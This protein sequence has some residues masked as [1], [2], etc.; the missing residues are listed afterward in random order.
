M[1]C[2]VSGTFAATGHRPN[3]AAP[4]PSRAGYPKEINH[5]QT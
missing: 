3:V 2:P 4:A 5:R 1:A